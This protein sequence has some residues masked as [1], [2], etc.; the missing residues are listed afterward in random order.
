MRVLPRIVAHHEVAERIHDVDAV[1]A[2]RARELARQ[3][4]N[5]RIRGIEDLKKL[6]RLSHI[7]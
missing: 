3:C 7:G 6:L 1:V 2:L 5:S 4:G